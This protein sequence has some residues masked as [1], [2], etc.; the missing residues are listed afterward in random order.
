MSRAGSPLGDE[1][2]R[3]SSGGCSIAQCFQISE[4]EK[5]CSKADS[6][7]YP[8]RPVSVQK[9]GYSLKGGQPTSEVSP[10]D[11]TAWKAEVVETRGD[12]LYRDKAGQREV[13]VQR[14]IQTR[15]ISL[16]DI[17][18]LSAT[19]TASAGR[20]QVS[21]TASCLCLNG[22]IFCVCHAA[23][24]TTEIRTSKK[25]LG[26]RPDEPSS[27]LNGHFQ[28][29]PDTSTLLHSDMSAG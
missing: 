24:G 1:V 17:Q 15:Y 21:R 2:A 12:K 27:G 29:V 13:H 8:S 25:R 16:S 6:L 22:S 4:C 28:Q 9:L 7:G 26:K 23:S 10:L 5:I 14:S 11:G 3:S 19:R 20:G 18:T